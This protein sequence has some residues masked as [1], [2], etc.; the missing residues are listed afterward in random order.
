MH[1][2]SKRRVYWKYYFHCQCQSL[3][4]ETGSTQYTT[5]PV[6][7][8]EFLQRDSEYTYTT[9]TVISVSFTE[10]QG[11]HIYY[12]HCRQCF[13]RDCPQPVSV[14]RKYM[15]LYSWYIFNVGVGN[16][17]LRH[18]YIH[19]VTYMYT[20]YVVELFSLCLTVSVYNISLPL[21]GPTCVFKVGTQDCE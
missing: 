7:R 16:T 13:Y 5:G 15:T 20:Y 1:R 14:I 21:Y 18:I 3:Y 17:C 8:S 10:R 2:D 19:N 11:V 4:R 9:G 12:R 6:V